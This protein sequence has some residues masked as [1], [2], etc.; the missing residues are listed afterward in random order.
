MLKTT[1]LSR[2]ITYHEGLL[3]RELL[4]FNHLVLQNHLTNLKCFISTTTIP[5]VSKDSSVPT[6]KSHYHL[7]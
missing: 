3:R 6:I 4:S 7:I 5:E 2:M 1:K